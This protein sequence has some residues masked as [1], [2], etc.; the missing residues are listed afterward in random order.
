MSEKTMYSAE[1]ITALKWPDAIRKRPGM[2]IGSTT[3]NGFVNMWKRMMTSLLQDRKSSKVVLE[4]INKKSGRLEFENVSDSITEKWMILNSDQYHSELIEIMAF[5]VLSHSFYVSFW[6]ESEAP[7]LIQLYEKGLLKTEQRTQKNINCKKV[8][9]DFEL[10][11]TI[12]AEDF[13]WKENYIRHELKNFAYLHKNTS[14][15]IKYPI[16]GKDCNMIYHFKNGLEDQLEIEKLN[17]LGGSYFETV[18]ENTIN[19]FSIELAFGFRNYSVDAPYIKS[20]VND[21]FTPENGSHVTGVLKGLTYG[22]MKYFQKHALTQ[23]YKI[24]EK[25]IEEILM[26]AINIR[27]KNPNFSGCVRNK[28]ANSE[29]IEPIA[30]HISTLLF[31]KMEKENDLTQRLIYKFKI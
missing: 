13:E 14:F 16:D 28:L 24:S 8:I 17:G 2:Y 1:N 19:D 12:W 9:I 25:G 10:D 15:E 30:N 11:E 18:V 26:A 29:I 4:L 5:T 7:V 21:H 22:V 23:E 27:M 3:V 20:Y 31:E 6:D